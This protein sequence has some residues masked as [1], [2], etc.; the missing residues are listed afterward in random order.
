MNNEL[1]IGL[2]GVV[3]TFIS[4]FTSWFFTRKKYNSEV[5]NTVINNLKEAVNTYKLIC[6]DNKRT[7]EEYIKGK[8]QLEE[9]VRDLRKQ[10]NELMMSIC[11][12]LTCSARQKLPINN[13]GKEDEGH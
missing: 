8:D 7:I 6:D 1:L 13:K 10:V 11:Y 2:I 12:D 3:T 9:E 4:G 5:D